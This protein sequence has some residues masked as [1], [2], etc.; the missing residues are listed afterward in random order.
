MAEP[1][2]KVEHLKKSYGEK[3]VLEDISF[4]VEEGSVVVLL[5]PSGSGKS[6]LIRCLNGLEAFQGG[7]IMF[8]GDRTAVAEKL[9]QAQAADRN[10]FPEL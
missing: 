6:T 4:E 2:L 10:G 1:L 3:Q 7:T 9:A 5:G 8:N